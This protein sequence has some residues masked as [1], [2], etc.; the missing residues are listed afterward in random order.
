MSKLL[1]PPKNMNNMTSLFVQQFYQYYC[2]ISC[3]CSW[4][5]GESVKPTQCFRHFKEH[6]S[7]PAVP[8]VCLVIAGMGLVILTRL[9]AE[10]FIHIAILLRQ[11]CFKREEQ[12][13]FLRLWNLASVINTERFL[14]SPSN[15]KSSG[16]VQDKRMRYCVSVSVF[17]LCP[18][19]LKNH[20]QH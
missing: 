9:L 2:V 4:Y 16:V 17:F 6:M 15:H 14:Q 10:A 7:I 3:Y 1:L 13:N 8:K 12:V 20:I 18:Q 5:G 19:A 11:P